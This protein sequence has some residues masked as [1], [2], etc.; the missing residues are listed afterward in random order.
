MTC[1]PDLWIDTRSLPNAS[2][3][4]QTEGFALQTSAKLVSYDKV[5][6][7]KDQEMCGNTANNDRQDQKDMGSSCSHN[8][9]C[10]KINI[11]H[12]EQESEEEFL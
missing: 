10:Q 12:K 9:D 4:D 2:E 5:E 1:S 8:Q 11:I 6:V 3:L 7:S